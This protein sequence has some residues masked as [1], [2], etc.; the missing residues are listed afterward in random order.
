MVPHDYEGLSH[1]FV[2]GGV[3]FWIGSS[4]NYSLPACAI[5]P[6]LG[7]ALSSKQDLGPRWRHRLSYAPRIYFG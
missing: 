6:K 5:S 3:V 7:L 4:A 1:Q 2:V